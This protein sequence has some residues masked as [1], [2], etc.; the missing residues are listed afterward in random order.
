[1]TYKLLK[2]LQY[3][4]L[5][6]N[7]FKSQFCMEKTAGRTEP[8]YLPFD[9]PPEMSQNSSSE[10]GTIVKNYYKPALI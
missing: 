7:S 5:L 1:M 6:A 3:V 2:W 10:K 8:V 9:I 4:D